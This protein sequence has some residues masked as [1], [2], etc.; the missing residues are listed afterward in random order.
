VTWELGDDA[1]QLVL[2][3]AEH[4]AVTTEQVRQF[5]DVDAGDARRL[6]NALTA[7]GRLERRGATKGTHYVLPTGQ[8]PGTP[9]GV[10]APGAW[11]E[12]IHRPLSPTSA[13]PVPTAGD[14][15]G[16]RRPDST[17]QPMSY[18]PIPEVHSSTNTGDSLL[19]GPLAALKLEFG[20]RLRRD[21][22]ELAERTEYRLTQYQ[23][24]LSRQSGWHT[25]RDLLAV[26]EVHEEL[27]RLGEL[28]LLEFS[29]EAAVID[30][31]FAP[32]FSDDEVERARQRLVDLGYTGRR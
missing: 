5:L 3:L 27:V 15:D 29:L 1:R 26:P 25:A 13:D 24:M 10:H 20:R 6:L 14:D 8:R 16:P 18:A 21:L 4:G 7:A 31:Q 2:E 17:S 23:R 9:P 11:L 12:D 22:S 19:D 28:G 32:L 30:P